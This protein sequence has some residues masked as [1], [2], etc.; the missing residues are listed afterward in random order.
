MLT[1]TELARQSGATP[2]A[3]RYY[4]RVG[5]LRPRQNPDNGY[6]LYKPREVG[7]LRFIQQAKQL[8]YTLNEIK[9]IMHDADQGRSP[10]PRVREILQ[11]RI[12]ENRRRLEEL[13]ALQT[14]MENAL[15]DWADKADGIPD[16]DS[17]CHLIES[18]GADTGKTNLKE[19]MS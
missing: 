15:L 1:V 3:V 10:C 6:H 18:F 12:V 16:G 19:G 11:Q 2:H 17:V 13:M 5:L 14:R 9:E 7:W 8:G 4:T